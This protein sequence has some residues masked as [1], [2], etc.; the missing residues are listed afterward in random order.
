M[1]PRAAAANPPN[2]G[3][4]FPSGGV[5]INEFGMNDGTEFIRDA[6]L[7][8]A[9][10]GSSSRGYRARA[11]MEPPA[12][13]LDGGQRCRLT[14]LR[15]VV[16][17]STD[18]PRERR[19]NSRRERGNALRRDIDPP[20][21]GEGDEHDDQ[22]DYWSGASLQGGSEDAPNVGTAQRTPSG[23]E[24]DSIEDV[25]PH[26][27]HS[28]TESMH[29]TGE[30]LD[31]QQAA[32]NAKGH[33]LALERE[34]SQVI[35]ERAVAASN[36]DADS[37]AVPERV[38]D[39]GKQKVEEK[40]KEPVFIEGVELAD[41]DDC[42]VPDRKLQCDNTNSDD[43]EGPNAGGIGVHDGPGS[44]LQTMEAN[45]ESASMLVAP[46]VGEHSEPL[47][48]AIAVVEDPLFNAADKAPHLDAMIVK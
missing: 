48:T 13:G 23:R 38:T 21:E 12:S 4:S 29:T 32:P 47:T 8:G 6:A 15:N 16:R 31:N 2:W 44:C 40:T 22:D 18:G 11:R 42:D 9:D 28:P 25:E 24:S 1:Q 33:V 17:A 20:T 10:P 41:L 39:K 43:D 30:E 37:E 7:S 3:T 46:E 34:S 35:A 26:S 19:K 27:Y 5:Q 45:D 14:R 36:P